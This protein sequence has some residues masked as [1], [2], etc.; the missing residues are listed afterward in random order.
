MKCKFYLF[1]FFSSLFTIVQ[2]Q[3]N[4]DSSLRSIYNSASHKEV[5][6][7]NIYVLGKVW[8]FLKYYHPNIAAG[9]YDWDKELID[10][11]PGYT[12]VASL[13][14]RNDSLLAWIKRFGEIPA[15][16]NCNDS[17]LEVA[18]LKPDFT[19]INENDFS[20]ELLA[21][22]KNIKENRIQSG[23]YYTK[24]QTMDGV[25]FVQF[26]HESAYGKIKFPND[27][28]GLLSLFRF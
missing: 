3:Q 24:F 22:L 28:Y 13:K 1:L 2:A 27:A 18:K 21:L 16:K 25:T 14:E 9:K 10:F 19:W 4:T 23:Q 5:V 15:C 12:K 17:I 8:G 20:P 6:S 7:D 26:Q 11:L